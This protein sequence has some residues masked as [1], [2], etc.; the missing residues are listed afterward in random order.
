[1]Q[2]VTEKV[3]KA[4]CLVLGSPTYWYCMS[5][6]M[7]NFIDRLTAL[8]MLEPPGLDGK[9]FGV[10]STAHILQWEQLWCHTMMCFQMKEKFGES[11]LE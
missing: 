1:M 5:G 9:V 2:E 3:R 8:D 4:D 7:K 10:V 11:S 6:L